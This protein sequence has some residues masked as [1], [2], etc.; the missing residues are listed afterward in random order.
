MTQRNE[1]PTLIISLLVTAALLGG[2]LWLLSRRTATITPPISNN[3]PSPTS[4]LP[5]PPGVQAFVPPTSVDP[6]TTVKIDGSTSM[7]QINK[8]F[9][10]AF[11][12]KFPG[13]QIIIDARG[14]DKGILDLILGKIDIAAAS[15]SLTPEQKAQG[16]IAVPVLQDAI[17]LVVGESNPYTKGLTQ[18]QVKD[19]FQGRIT[20]WAEVGGPSQPIRVINRPAISGTHQVFQAQ[21]L[22]GE[23][24][25]TTPNI[26]TQERDA[27]TPILQALG[28]DG[29]SYASYAQ[30][31]DQTT[32]K[33]LSIDDLTPESPNYAYQRTLYYVYKDPPSPGVEAFLGFV[34]S[35]EGQ[36]LLQP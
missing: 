32:V 18:K 1:I 4:P 23:D 5:S 10:Q 33:T 3:S 13:T 24:F 35:L 20:N 21:A 31:A 2:G 7:A 6:G 12:S 34:T 9:Q 36:N 25:G 27:T 17:A 16:L 14:T 26:L 30:V 11:E 22:K 28:K 15:S 19:I 8:K 29:I